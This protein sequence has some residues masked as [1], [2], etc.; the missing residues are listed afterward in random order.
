M[1]EQERDAEL[2]RHVRHAMRPFD[3]PQPHW[4]PPQPQPLWALPLPEPPSA[5]AQKRVSHGLGLA[6]VAGQR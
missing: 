2:L 3:L 4:I 5:L 1:T 6:D